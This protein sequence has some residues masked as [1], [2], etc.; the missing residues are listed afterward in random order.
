[1]NRLDRVALSDSLLVALDFDGTLSPIVPAPEQARPLGGA[2]EA[3][4]GLLECPG[5]NV[6]IVSGRDVQDLLHRLDGWPPIWLAGSHGR[7]ILAPGEE[8]A[9]S[10]ADPRLAWVREAAVLDGIRREAKTFSVAF[11]WRGRREGEPVGWIRD[12]VLR[13]RR[14]GLEVLEGRQVLEILVPGTTK[15][16]A[17]LDL[18][19]RT[20]SKDLVYAGDDLTDLE[21][22]LLAAERGVGL[23]VKSGER[24]WNPPPGVVQLGSPRALV[25]WLAG[26]VEA[27]RRIA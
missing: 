23:F 13:A 19:K 12:L 15:D 22:I 24:P 4:R 18:R 16:L 20:A 1:M 25:D 6:A 9:P 17:L 5:T 8:P 3:V 11:H 26:L 21:A 7:T 14:E 27:R 10:V 2:L